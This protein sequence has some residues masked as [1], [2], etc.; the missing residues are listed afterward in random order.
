M[1]DSLNIIDLL[2][3]DWHDELRLNGNNL[4]DL[5]AFLLCNWHLSD[6]LNW[7]WLRGCKD[8]LL[9]L[10]FSNNST[11]LLGSLL[12]KLL[13]LVEELK[14]SQFF[15]EE[16]ESA[17]LMDAGEDEEK[18]DWAHGIQ[19]WP[20]LDSVLLIS[21]HIWTVVVATSSRIGFLSLSPESW[22]I[23]SVDLLLEV[24]WVLHMVVLV[25]IV[26]ALLFVIVSSLEL[27]SLR[28]VVLLHIVHDLSEVVWDL[29]IL[30]LVELHINLIELRLE[31]VAN[32]IEMIISWMVSGS[33]VSLW[34]LSNVGG[35]VE[36]VS[37]GF[38]VW[39]GEIVVCLDVIDDSL[40]ESALLSSENVEDEEGHEHE[41]M[42]VEH[43]F[44]D[45]RL[46]LLGS[47]KSNLTHGEEEERNYGGEE[48]HI[49]ERFIKKLLNS[50]FI[51]NGH[52]G[53][54]EASVVCIAPWKCFRLHD[55][56]GFES[57]ISHFPK[58]HEHADE[59]E[60]NEQIRAVLN[61]SCFVFNVLL[62]F[63]DF[64]IQS[65]WSLDHSLW[66]SLRLKVHL[67]RWLGG[68]VDWSVDNLLDWL[69]GWLSLWFNDLNRLSLWLLQNW[70]FELHI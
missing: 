67:L 49:P 66:Y 40:E 28:V 62:G 9:W 19:L 54:V 63:V 60:S 14:L 25:V 69:L 34:S 7:S 41:E 15:L 68:N 64:L 32:I 59:S 43:S 13:S 6:N 24:E 8:S 5:L 31:M 52:I 53:P 39:S 55:E 50:A 45:S 47:S 11:L 23:D 12:D 46:L 22:S 4:L 26:V 37:V 57:R 38:V 18:N 44:S 35:H 33:K 61:S 51:S 21:H 70:V 17:D 10:L 42:S 58:A 20:V 30:S 3:H 29:L 1:R 2:G 27:M 56:D 48:H 65:Q 16:L 36:N